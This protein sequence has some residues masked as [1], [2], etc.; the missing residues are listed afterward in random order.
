MPYVT[1]CQIVLFNL[2]KFGAVMDRFIRIVGG[3]MALL[4]LK[5]KGRVYLS[6][7]FGIR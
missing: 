2:A 3:C 6:N 7:V 5:H 1:G 4:G